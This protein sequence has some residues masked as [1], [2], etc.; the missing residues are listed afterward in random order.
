MSIV[1]VLSLMA[2]TACLSGC[3]KD[4]L[5]VPASDLGPVTLGQACIG[6]DYSG[7]I[8]Y[9]I[10]TNTIVGSNSKMDWDLAFECGTDGWH[11]RLNG[12]RFMRAVEKPGDDITQPVDTSG[13]GPFWR[14]DHNSGSL[15]STA[16]RDWRTEQ[17]VYT[18]DLG[19]NTLGLRMGVRQL[20]VL[21][22]DANGYTFEIA[23]MNGTNVQTYS[24]AKDPQ[25]SWT[26]F[27]ISGGQTV[28]IAPPQGSYDLVITQYTYQFY[29]PYTA[30]LVTGAVNGYSGCRVSRL[31]ADFAAVTLAD[32]LAH[33]FTR[34]EDGVGY[35]WK[36]YDFDASLYTVFPDHVFIVQD[37]EGVYFKLHF[38]DFYDENGQRGCPKFE[39][40]AL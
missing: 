12:A 31:T 15:D 37:A 24:V 32:T 7:Q 3:L 2:L 13:F 35:E 16:I 34:D 22:A 6:T 11:V 39:V 14:I 33:P 19:Y 25:R 29:D 17:P 1:R 27:R 38:T 18:L 23:A 8:W 9:D 26:H 28:T 5:P 20:R 40:V 10:G 4:E 21:S 36:E 30:Y